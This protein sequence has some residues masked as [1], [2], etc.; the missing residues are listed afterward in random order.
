MPTHPIQAHLR[1]LLLAGRV[2]VVNLVN[3]LANELV[4]AVNGRLNDLVTALNGLLNDLVTA[5]NGLLND[6][7]TVNDVVN[8]LLVAVNDLVAAFPLCCFIQDTE[9][10]CLKG[11]GEARVSDSLSTFVYV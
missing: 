3:D 6:L 1:S 8:D 7:V 4:T 9:K 11:G 10:I 5:L 2:N